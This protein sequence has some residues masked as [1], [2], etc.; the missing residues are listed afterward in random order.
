MHL[1]TGGSVATE[2][3]IVAPDFTK[4]IEE[5]KPNTISGVPTTYK[6]AER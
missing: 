2:S 1:Y 5:F 4:L 6:L 3:S